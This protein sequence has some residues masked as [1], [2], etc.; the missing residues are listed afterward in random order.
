MP[1]QI[2]KLD[3]RDKLKASENDP[4]ELR[5][6]I[7]QLVNDGQIKLGDIEKATTYKKST[8]SQILHDKYEGDQAK[9]LDAIIRWYR[10][11]VARHTI[12]RTSVV[13]DINAVIEMVWRAKEIGMIVSPFGKGKSDAAML[14]A[15]E[16]SDYARF[17][18]LSGA[19]S[20]VELIE[21]I[22]EALDITEVMTGSISNR[23]HAIIRSLQRAPKVLI[24]DEADELRPKSLKLLRD[25]HGDNQERCGVVLI[26][27][28]KL[29]RL[30]QNPDLGYFR[31]RIAIK[32][33]V[34]DLPFDEAKIIMDRFDHSLDNAELKEAWDWSKRHDSIRSLVNLFK[35]ASRIADMKDIEK[36]DGSCLKEAYAWLID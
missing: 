8:V 4:Q 27:N 32:R 20:P 10:Y 28:E 13:E 26:A 21:K 5:K 35:M 1:T 2:L 36:I 31:S 3:Y 7:A 19:S 34:E 24:I 12:V 18:E 15:A 17:I 16:H 9:P 14:Y 33:R 30:L 29:L 25:I 22:G 6:Q 23:L 11:W